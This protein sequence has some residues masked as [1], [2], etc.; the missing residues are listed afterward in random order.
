MP[1]VTHDLNNELTV[2]VKTFERAPKL[3]FLLNSVRQTLPTVR[4]LVADDSSDA[5]KRANAATCPKHNAEHLVLPYDVG[6]SVGRNHMLERVKTPFFL[7]MDDDQYFG[8]DT[9][10]NLGMQMLKA[11]GVD[12][13]GW[14]V[15]D[16]NGVDRRFSGNFWAM[17]DRLNVLNAHTIMRRP[18]W[19]CPVDLVLNSFI[20]ATKPVQDMGGWYPELKLGEHKEFFLRGLFNGLKV[21]YTPRICVHE[22]SRASDSPEY[23]KMRGR[24]EFVLKMRYAVMGV[25]NSEIFHDR[26]E[27]IELPDPWSL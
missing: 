14:N 20:A 6:L 4:I 10:L 24:K 18:N 12:L 9:D 27:P 3:A 22:Q 13:V 7:L 1:K 19:A 26:V 17:H 15:R 23:L 8:R 16:A 21:V 11:Y 25:E 5:T 2:L